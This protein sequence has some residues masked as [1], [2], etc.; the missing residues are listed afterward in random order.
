[1]KDLLAMRCFERRE[2][3]PTGVESILEWV[4]LLHPVAHCLAADELG[5]EERPP[6]A[7]QVTEV[8]KGHA[9]GVADRRHRPGLAV[10]PLAGEVVVARLEKLDRDQSLD[11]Q[12]RRSPDLTERP[13][14]ERLLEAKATHEH[15]AGM[16]T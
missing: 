11:R 2:H 9:V 4:G 12:L 16:E 6:V 13:F 14:S 15:R 7:W 10:E 5:D 8:E 3:L 1:M